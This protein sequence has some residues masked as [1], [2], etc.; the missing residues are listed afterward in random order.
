M[1]SSSKNDFV[2]IVTSQ[3]RFPFDRKII[4][5]EL[6]DH[7]H[8]LETF[9]VDEV[10]DPQLAHMKA[11]E[12]MGDPV[13]I[14]KELNLVHKPIWGWLWFFSKTVCIVLAVIVF[15]MSLQKVWT[16][17]EAAQV[18]PVPSQPASEILSVLTPEAPSSGLIIDL[19]QR[20][21]VM[22]N[23]DTLL[24]DRVLLTS[25]G[26]LIILYQDV[27]DLQSF[28]VGS[29]PYPV[30]E[31]SSLV[32]A[33]DQ[34]IHFNLTGPKTYLNHEVLIAENIPTDITSITLQYD[35][36]ADR[37]TVTFQR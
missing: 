15:V 31:L 25:D 32:M 2:T 13:E 19:S 27:K 9:Y 5:I 4:A 36:Y 35:G 34:M 33:N 23:G 1:T 24:F 28:L 16:A 22:I 21:R 6:Q 20:Q 37:F 8:E 26:I 10:H 14:G 30:R 12:E 29:D 11:I 3:V 7:I 17:A 18:H